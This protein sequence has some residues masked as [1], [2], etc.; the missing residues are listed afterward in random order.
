MSP[1]PP[2]A[3]HRIPP[4]DAARIILD[5]IRPLPAERRPL[6]E[7]LGRVLATD[8]TSP[9]DVPRWDNSAMDGYAVRTDDLV[10]AEAV[11]AVLRVV[12]EI[13]AGAFPTRTLGP[14]ECAQV[15]TGAPVPDGA[16]GVIRQ[17]H[18]TRMDD[19][20][21]RIDDTSDV[22]G[23]IRR[24]GEDIVRGR[25]VLAAGAEL[26]GPQLGVL[27]SVAQAEVDVVRVPRVALFTTGDELARLE[28]ADLILAGEMIASS[29]SYTMLA[30]VLEA[31]AEAVDLGIV[32]DDRDAVRERLARAA[33][34]DLIVTSGG[35]SVGAYDYLRQILENETAVAFWRLRSR[36]GA[37]VGFGHFDGTPWIGLPGNPVSTMVAFE[38]FVRPA[39]RRLAG[40][41]HP[42]RRA[43]SVRVAERMETPGSLTHFLRVRLQED[44]TGMPTARLTGPQGS[45]ILTSM[46]TADALLVVP[47]EVEVSETGDVRQAIVLGDGVHV[48]E[49]PY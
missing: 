30:A 15:F 14:G 5:A 24:R 10:G 21:V 28:D 18:T 13:A 47:E 2:P 9:V 20:R 37:P 33:Q 4:R 46:A 23:N 6:V 35:M 29:N 25:V 45:G 11:G 7:A 34:A 38:L 31:R 42:F 3:H 27:A 48:S 40:H 43:V 19:D 16:D 44:E 39:I 32:P 17:E 41:T 12:E 36:P 49:A 8:V 22:G 1:A 26:G